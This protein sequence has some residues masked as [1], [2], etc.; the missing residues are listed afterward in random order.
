[1]TFDRNF[2][3]WSLITILIK[4]VQKYRILYVMTYLNFRA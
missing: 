2:V 1:M 3:H 4:L